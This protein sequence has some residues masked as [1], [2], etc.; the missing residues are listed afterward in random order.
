MSTLNLSCYRQDFN[1]ELTSVFSAADSENRRG[2]TEIKHIMG[3]YRLWD[4][5]HESFPG[6]LIDNCAS[7]GR[8]IDIETLRRSI[9]FFRSDYQCNFNEN[10]E[11]LQT[12]N[13]TSALY[14]PYIGCT[15]K[16][17]GD[18]YAIRSS[19]A[20]S[21]GGAFYNAIFQSMDE[22]D[23][24]WAK[25]VTDEYRSIRRYFSCDFYNHGASVFDDTSWAIFQYHDPDTDSGILMAFRRAR[26]PFDSVS[27]SLKGLAKDCAYRFAST[28]G[29]TE[30]EFT[31]NLT[32][33]L[34]E[35]RSSIILH[36]ERK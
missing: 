25:Q 3:M 12:H 24:A 6:L 34:P 22:A 14:F 1:A 5:L 21:W 13:A 27:L 4:A 20:S 8:R 35:R 7:G 19:Y 16:T 17:K 15:T 11:V 29:A 26:S 2:I 36:Y 23:F 9:P 33:S 10:P 30:G 18:I 31:D 28:D 32:V